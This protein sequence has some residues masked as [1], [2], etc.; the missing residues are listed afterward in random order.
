MAAG[1]PESVATVVRLLLAHKVV[2]NKR[3]VSSVVLDRLDAEFFVNTRS[4]ST[5][6][7]I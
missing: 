1:E 3:L 2:L 5:L 4:L 6:L 7:V